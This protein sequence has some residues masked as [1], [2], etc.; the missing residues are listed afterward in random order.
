MAKSEKKGI[1]HSILDGKFEIVGRNPSGV[2]SIQYGTF[3]LANLSEKQAQFLVDKK[4][5][6]INKVAE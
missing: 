1:T 6:W 5:P 4:V 2:I 3:D